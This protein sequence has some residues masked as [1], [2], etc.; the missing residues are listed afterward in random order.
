MHPL[1]EMSCDVSERDTLFGKSG[2]RHRVMGD[3]GKPFE[4][5]RTEVNPIDLDERRA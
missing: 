3:G 4:E 1:P 5:S 2:K